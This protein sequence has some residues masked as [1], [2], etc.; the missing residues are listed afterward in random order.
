MGLRLR[1]CLRL[2]LGISILGS[3]LAVVHYTGLPADV[4]RQA[5]SCK[6]EQVT[7]I[8]FWNDDTGLFQCGPDP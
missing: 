8:P 2:E 5:G 3:A 7:R 1:S 6:P 4:G